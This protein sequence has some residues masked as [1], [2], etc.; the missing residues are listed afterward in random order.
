MT[1]PVIQWQVVTPAPEKHAAF[2]AELFGWSIDADNPL[3]YRRAT[4]GSE[5]GIDGGFWPAPPETRP[6]V[7]LYVEVEDV[8]VSFARAQ[9]LGCAVI[10]PPQA[11]PDGDELAILHDP[12]GMPFGLVKR[13]DA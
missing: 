11:L 7:Q 8:G 13:R 6:F 12:V 10:A 5:R 3:A 2:Y 4:S 9:E 1:S